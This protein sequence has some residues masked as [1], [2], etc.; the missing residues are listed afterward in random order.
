MMEEGK[1]HRLEIELEDMKR[2]MIVLERERAQTL[3]EANAET[4]SLATAAVKDLMSR[5]V[6]SCPGV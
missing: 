3:R 4:L 1:R 2:H 6:T 5:C